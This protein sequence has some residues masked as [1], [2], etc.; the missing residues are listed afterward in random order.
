MRKEV[1][2]SNFQRGGHGEIDAE[3]KFKP[4]V[5]SRREGEHYRDPEQLVAD[6]Y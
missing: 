5:Y 2:D 4:E 3:C 1:H 6:L